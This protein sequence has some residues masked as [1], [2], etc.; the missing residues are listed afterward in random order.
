MRETHC[1]GCDDSGVRQG[2][3]QADMK[4]VAFPKVWL[5]WAMTGAS[6]HHT[7]LEYADYYDEDGHTCTA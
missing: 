4:Y 6:A 2:P 7:A 1:P 5:C 3:P